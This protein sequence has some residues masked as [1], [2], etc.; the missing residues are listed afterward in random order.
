MGMTSF[1]GCSATPTSSGHP[2]FL[3]QLP[4]ADWQFRRRD[5]GGKSKGRLGGG[6]AAERQAVGQ[7]M[8]PAQDSTRTRLVGASG[9]LVLAALYAILML[10]EWWPIVVRS[11][12]VRIAEYHFGSESMMAH[13]GWKYA[14]AGLYAWTA[15][16][17]AALAMITGGAFSVAIFRRSRA[18]LACGWLLVVAW[19]AASIFAPRFLG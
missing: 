5:I 12:A 15:F 8:D 6:L 17:Q 18:A 1:V 19:V 4:L 2:R 10:S 13:G 11:D 3:A 9:V 14:S 7:T 16:A